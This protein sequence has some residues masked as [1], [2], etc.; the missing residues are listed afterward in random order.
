MSRGVFRGVLEV[1]SVRDSLACIGFFRIVSLT[2]AEVG[3]GKASE[4]GH[5]LSVGGT[6][7]VD[8]L[9]VNKKI[10]H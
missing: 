6:T 2:S 10:L 5:P 3:I 7:K 4:S 9:E 1:L 8:D